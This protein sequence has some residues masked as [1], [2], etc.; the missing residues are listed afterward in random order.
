MVNP[1]ELTRQDELNSKVIINEAEITILSFLSIVTIGIGTKMVLYQLDKLYHIGVEMALFGE[2]NMDVF[3]KSLE[4]Y[5]ITTSRNI[6][7][8]PFMY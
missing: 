6:Y 7:L 8:T 2:V 3:Q 5:L 1:I 4:I